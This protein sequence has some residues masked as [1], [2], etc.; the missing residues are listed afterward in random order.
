MGLIFYWKLD[1]AVYLSGFRWSIPFQGALNGVVAFLGL[2]NLE[3]MDGDGENVGKKYYFSETSTVFMRLIPYK[4]SFL[5]R[6][7]LIQIKTGL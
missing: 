6:C 3:A 7:T 4:G 1:L 5:D 2:P